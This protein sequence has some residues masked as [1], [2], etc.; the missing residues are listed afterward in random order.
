MPLKE[1]HLKKQ[2]LNIPLSMVKLLITL[3]INIPSHYK[4]TGV[5]PNSV[6]GE[7]GNRSGISP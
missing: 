7:E 1:G 5:L 2:T 3:W 6:A 4:D